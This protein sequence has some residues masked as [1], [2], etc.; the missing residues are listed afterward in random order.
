M[1]MLINW[2]GIVKSI[3]VL[4]KHLILSNLPDIKNGI[5]AIAG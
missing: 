5:I 1:G 4:V 3:F 2:V